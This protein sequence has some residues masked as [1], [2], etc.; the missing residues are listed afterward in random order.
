MQILITN[1]DG[2]HAPGLVA[3]WTAL[4]PRHQVRVVAPDSEQSAVG[5]AI[6]LHTPLRVRRLPGDAGDPW[7]A[8]SGTP[9]DCVKIAVAELLERPP[10][11]VVSGV[12]RGPNVGINLLYSGTVSAATEAGIL[13]IPALA[14]SLDTYEDVDFSLAAQVAARLVDWGG[15]RAG[16]GPAILNVNVPALPREAIRGLRWARQALGA[17]RERYE[18]RQDPRANTY[19]WL[20]GEAPPPAEAVSDRAALAAGYITLTPLRYDLTDEAALASRLG[21]AIESADLGL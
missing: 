16:P 11:L 21:A 12:N 14:V 7:L 3:L 20:A 4:A 15:W 13:G 9:A 6:S 18:R 1:D 10:D 17:P 19:Y 5:H 8:V 2:I